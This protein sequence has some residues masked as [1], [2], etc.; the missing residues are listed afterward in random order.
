MSTMALPKTKALAGW[1]GADRMLA[2][3][4]GQ[5]LA[6][7]KAAFVL[8]AGGMSALLHIKARTLIVNDLHRH[9]INLARVAGHRMLGPALYRRLKR[10]AFHP[11]ELKGAQDYCRT[12]EELSEDPDSLFA[13]GQSDPR[14]EKGPDLDWAVAYFVCCWQ[15][16]GG[17]AGQKNEFNGN[18]SLRYDAGGGDSNTRFRSA[19]G[20]L[21]A[22]RR[23]VLGRA[24]FTCQDAFALL[25]NIGD[26]PENGIYSDAPWVGPGELYRHTFKT[27]DHRRLALKLSSYRRA[28]VVVRYGICPLIEEL[29]PRDKWT[30]REQTSRAQSNGAVKEALILNGP[31]FATEAA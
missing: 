18:L 22:W 8:F 21:V 11:D 1:Y 29:Y 20:G 31:S 5:E 4:V 24:T 27:D 7:S 30:Y 9:Q 6:G 2:H 13:A 17:N 3:T 16:R 23:A 28:R 19:V 15:G 26:D 12:R 25:D 14:F 10:L